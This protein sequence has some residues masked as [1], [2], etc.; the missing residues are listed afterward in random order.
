MIDGGSGPL[1]GVRV[2]DV[3]TY[4]AGPS[5]GMTLAQ[6]GADVIRGDPVGGATDVRRLPLDRN[7]RSLYWAGLNKGK[8]SIEIDTSSAVGRDLVARLLS[9]P[10]DGNG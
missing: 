9:V 8:R 10:G 7:G 4:V 6:L 3:S 5:G 1:A 2:V